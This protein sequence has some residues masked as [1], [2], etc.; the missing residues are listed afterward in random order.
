MYKQWNMEDTLYWLA[1]NMVPGVGPSA[2][3]NLIAVFRDP[4]HV[5]AAS[6]RALA[7]VEGIGDKTIGAIKAFPAV[8]AAT[9]E[10]KKTEDLEVSILTFRLPH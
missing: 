8:A 2:Y 5:F 7:A 3:R 10:L 9:E 4:E 1:L 6:P